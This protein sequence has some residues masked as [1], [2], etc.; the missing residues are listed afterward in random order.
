MFPI[1]SIG[2]KEVIACIE[3]FALPKVS[4]YKAN[5]ANSTLVPTGGT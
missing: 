1:L 5:S 4:S 3:I 2:F